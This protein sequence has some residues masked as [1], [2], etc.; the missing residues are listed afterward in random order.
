MEHI[1]DL[2]RT[3]LLRIG[4]VDSNDFLD[5]QHPQDLLES[6]WRIH[7]KQHNITIAKANQLIT[8]AIQKIDKD[9]IPHTGQR[10]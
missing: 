8:D 6:R 3:Q 4:T 5:G 10:F 1:E 2:V 7:I 9:F